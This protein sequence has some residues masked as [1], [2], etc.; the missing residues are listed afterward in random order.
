[1]VPSLIATG[2]S[3]SAVGRTELLFTP[4]PPVDAA[5]LAEGACRLCDAP[6]ALEVL[7]KICAVSSCRIVI[8]SADP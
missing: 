4:I 5:R 6:L 2:D 8:A 7:A 3:V 1:M